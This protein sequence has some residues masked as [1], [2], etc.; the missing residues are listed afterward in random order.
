MY[1]R[2]FSKPQA[3]RPNPFFHYCIVFRYIK[4]ASK[5]PMQTQYRIWRNL[6]L[7]TGLI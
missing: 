4:T 7:K 1:I 2:S 3:S 6:S 5:N